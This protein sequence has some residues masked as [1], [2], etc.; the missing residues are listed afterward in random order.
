MEVYAGFISHTDAEIGRLVD[1]IRTAPDADNTLILYV[2][3]DNGAA[4]G[5]LE[6]PA[7]VMQEQLR[8]IDD[9]GSAKIPFNHYAGGWAWAGS[10]PFQWWKMMASHFGGVRNPLVVSWPARIKDKGGLRSQFTHVN[11]VAATIYDAAGITF[12]AAVDGVEQQPLDGTSFVQTLAD[13]T[14]LSSHH[15]QYFEIMG[16]RAVYQDGWVAAARHPASLD[17][18]ASNQADYS[19]DR[20]ELYHVAEDFSQAEDLARKQPAKLKELQKLFEAEARKNHV[21][22]LGAE[23]SPGKPSLTSSKRKFVYYPETRRIPDALLPDLAKSSYRMSA[24]VI[25]PEGGAEGVLAA[26]G[27]RHS[28]FLWYVKGGRLVYENRAGPQHQVLTSQMPLP[29]G[30]TLLAFAYEKD[31]A[32]KSSNWWWRQ[33]SSGTARLYINGE[34]AAQEKLPFVGQPRDAD[35][36]LGR[37][38]RSPAS[39]VFRQ[40][41]EFTGT[42]EK[43]TVELQ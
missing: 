38:A 27:D 39:P 4:G 37:R 42:L 17:W 25:I 13:A 28:G 31:P 22:P 14:A 20:W 30:R 12:P 15:I 16:N 10:T 19:K 9:L 26:Y 36:F 11:D 33:S 8:L 43:V 21:Y 34:L 5:I 29:F 6:F 24:D 18:Y 2:V 7:E 41:F 35:M 23:L 32:H 1:A 40:S 3:G